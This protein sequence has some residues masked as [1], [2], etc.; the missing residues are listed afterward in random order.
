[1]SKKEDSYLSFKSNLEKNNF[2][3]FF[4][5]EQPRN[6]TIEYEN[7]NYFKP[8]IIKHRTINGKNN[9]NVNR[10]YNSNNDF[11]YN[12]NY[13]NRAFSTNNI[14]NNKKPNIPR[15]VRK[16]NINKFLNK[17]YKPREKDENINNFNQKK[18]NQNNNKRTKSIENNNY[19]YNSNQNPNYILNS[20]RGCYADQK[21]NHQK[22]NRNASYDIK[23]NINEGST[24]LLCKNCF[25]K[26]MLEEENPK[27]KEIDRI[28]YLNN[29]FINENPYYFIDKMSENEKR[30]IT[31]KIESNSNK[32]RL[33]YVT[34]KKAIDNP[35]N[36]TKEQLQLINEYSIN[37]LTIEVGK[38]PRY[39]KQK[40]SYDKKEKI[41]QQN[42]DKFKSL[43][44]RK[45]YNDYYNKCI[46]QIP[47]MEEMYHVNSVYK[48]N[49]IK[50]LK[51]QI[52]DKKNKEYEDKKKQRNA[53]AVAIQKFNDYKK[54]ANLNE[55][56]KHNYGI[57]LL[58]NDNILLE[59]FKKYKNNL[60]KEQERQLE[61][62]RLKN[63]NRIDNDL[64]LRSK[65]QKRNNIETYQDWLDNIDKKKQTKQEK[66]D[67]ENKKWNNYI[68]NYNLKCKHLDVSSCDIC[69]RPYRKEKL[70]QFPPSSSEKVNFYIN[71]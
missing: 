26:K 59:D 33:A 4:P 8:R 9:N 22:I 30:R 35:K 68:Q 12:I 65:N 5:N 13:H 62:E 49:Y 28:E 57:E 53:E 11:N 27:N 71:N 37:P 3:Y 36:N 54:I 14:N 51:K 16:K 34:F 23:L 70:R 21:K 56:E 2:E 10:L 24:N 63:N 47:K 46:Y 42:P 43:E 39:L 20:G 67:E 55:K 25:D 17:N 60:F 52:E 58:K 38:D 31:D 44:P 15:I 64:K 18:D 32:Q 50:A 69:N 41:I 61:T 48:E 1:M 29:K 66:K 6:R 40:Q 45:A 7:K 19:M